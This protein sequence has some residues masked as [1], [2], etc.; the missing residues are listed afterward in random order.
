MSIYMAPCCKRLYLEPSTLELTSQQVNINV[1]CEL[2]NR[3]MG[4][5]R[6]PQYTAL[7]MTCSHLCVM[8]T[9]A[10]LFESIDDR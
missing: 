1:L 2:Q 3:D 10:Q 4:H 8:L 6:P 7:M 9:H 5:D